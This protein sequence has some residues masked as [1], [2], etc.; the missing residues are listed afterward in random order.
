MKINPIHTNLNEWLYIINAWNLYQK[1]V[2][3]KC[4]NRIDISEGLHV[5]K[6][7]ASKELNNKVNIGISL[8]KEFKFQPNAC[9]RCYDLLMMPMNLSDIAF[10]NIKSVDYWGTISGISKREMI[11]FIRNIDLSEKSE[12]L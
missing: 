2:Y 10:L 3:Y 12:T 5:N 8:N 7:S 6:T 11:N 9:N 1:F 4:F